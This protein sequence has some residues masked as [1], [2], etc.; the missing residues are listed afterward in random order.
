MHA[1]VALSA[2]ALALTA[3][4][5]TA[6]RA[7]HRALREAGGLARAVGRDATAGETTLERLEA[8][9]ARG[10]KDGPPVVA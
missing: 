8:L 10:G 3:S 5:A 1:A 2:L 9:K 6:I 4:R 7:M